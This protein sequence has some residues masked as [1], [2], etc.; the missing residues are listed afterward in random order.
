MVAA[1]RHELDA[2]RVGRNLGGSEGAGLKLRLRQVHFVASACI[3]NHAIYGDVE[4]RTYEIGVAEGAIAG[5]LAAGRRQEGGVFIRRRIPIRILVVVLMHR[6]RIAP[7]VA[8]SRR[9][10]DGAPGPRAGRIATAPGKQQFW[11][12]RKALS[13]HRADGGEHRWIRTVQHFWIEFVAAMNRENIPIHGLGFLRFPKSR[14]AAVGAKTAGPICRTKELGCTEK[15]VG[16][17]PV[18]R[19]I[20]VVFWSK[21]GGA[22]GLHPAAEIAVGA[23]EG[24][25]HAPGGDLIFVEPVVPAWPGTDNGDLCATALVG[26]VRVADVARAP[27]LAAEIFRTGDPILASAVGATSGAPAIGINDATVGN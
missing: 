9:R 11:G 14:T 13:V 8:R 27:G 21:P 3:D 25:P 4:E 12:R 23:F 24:R 18:T 26:R 6:V 22:V 16:L 7:V 17:L 2:R 20:H 10:T 5:R 15:P 1:R 19:Q